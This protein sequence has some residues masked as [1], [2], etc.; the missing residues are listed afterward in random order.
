[1]KRSLLTAMAIALLI[2]TGPRVSHAVPTIQPGTR[3]PITANTF[4]LPIQ[5]TDAA[6]VIAWSFTLNYDPSDLQIN[7]G[8]DPFSGDVYCGFLPITGP[9][10]EGDFFA[11]GM[12]F[13]AFIP[14]FILLDGS[15]NQLGTLLAVNNT[16]AGNLPGPSGSGVL[17]YVEFLQIGN[18]DSR[19]TVTDTSTTTVPEPASLLLLTGGLALLRGRGLIK[20][21]GRTNV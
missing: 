6:N 3:I 5:I 10:T 13:N 21:R 7:T 11:T 8:C 1:M 4:A 16:F 12:P 2:I 18:G 9:V 20:R 17:A 19:I 15:L 14:G